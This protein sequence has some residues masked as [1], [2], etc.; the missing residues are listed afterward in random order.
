MLDD[1]VYATTSPIYV[2]VE[3]SVPKPADD[4]AFFIA[5]IDRLV[6]TTKENRNWNTTAERD[7][8]L[9]MLDEARQVYGRLQR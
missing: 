4:A 9:Q 1:Y 5:W 7:S 8:V 2:N 3:G 6:A